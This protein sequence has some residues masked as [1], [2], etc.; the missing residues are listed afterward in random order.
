MRIHQFTPFTSTGPKGPVRPVAPSC[1]GR[2]R[3]MT[4][5]SAS[6]SAGQQASSAGSSS[7]DSTP[8]ASGSSSNNNKPQAWAPPTGILKIN[9]ALLQAGGLD[10]SREGPQARASFEGHLNSLFLP[11]NLDHPGIRVLN[12]DPPVLTVEGFLTPLECDDIVRTATDSGLMR[13]SGVGVGGY[14]LK[15]SGDVRTSSTLAAT[16]E[17]LAQ[18]PAL[19]A[20]LHVMLSRARCL[21]RGP[22]PPEGPAAFSRPSQPGQAAFEL[23]QVARYQPGQHFLTHEDAFPSSVVASKGYQRRATLLLYLNDCGEG[24]STKFDILDIAVQPRKGTALLF[25]PAFSNGVPD[26]RTLHTATDAVTEKWV[27]Q[28]WLSVG[29]RTQQQQQQLP[30]YVRGTRSGGPPGPKGRKRGVPPQ[31]INTKI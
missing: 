23:P 14:Q 4:P 11:V 30:A 8:A 12:I 24:G 29:V 31:R 9:P 15:D 20:A 5:A 6:A 19:S 27:T 1:V 21:L 16:T 17:V 18:Q 13:Q 28:L 26:R 22:L 2:P 10:V 3:P 25:F 7:S